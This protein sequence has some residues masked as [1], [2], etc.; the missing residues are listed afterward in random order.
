MTAEQHQF[1]A[2]VAKVLDIVINSLY[3]SKEIFL[4]ELISNA[5]DACDKL[6]Y[7]AL[8]N[9]DLLD[10]D[11]AYRISLTPDGEAKTLTI[12]DN[13]IGMNKDDLIT[14]LGTIA[15]SGTEAFVKAL[16]SG[17]DTVNQI[18]QF[19]VGFYSVFMV[20]SRAEVI[21]RKAGDAQAWKWASD[22][23]S[24]YSIEE[25]SKAT[26]GTDIILH[27]K[28]DQQ[29][30]TEETTLR[31]I[32]SRYSDH[33]DVPV[34]LQGKEGEPE[35]LNSGSALWTRNK[36][37]ITEDQYKEFYKHVSH[38]FDD[39]WHTMHYRA[40]G[41]IEYTG[42]L[43]V[44]T[45]KPLDLFDP[46]RKGH[47]KLYVRRVFITEDC[48]GLLPPYLRFL[49]GVVDTPDLPLN[50]SRELLQ[51]NP[52]LQKISNG[53]VK[54]V[55]S[56]LK[57][58]AK[59]ATAYATFWNAFGAVMKEGLYD[60]FARRE[61]LLEL[62]RFH[63]THGTELISLDD[64]IGRM[65]EGQ[66]DIYYLS[67]D[68]LETLRHSPQLEGFK[69]K[70]IEVLLLTDH[71]DEFW[72]PSVGQVQG[73][74]LKSAAAAGEDL[75]KLKSKTA[76]DKADETPEAELD[77]SA[78]IETLK[79]ELK[80]NVKDI[81]V[82]DRLTESPVCLVSAD[83]DMSMQLERLMRQHDQKVSIPT[84]IM[85]INPKH[86]LIKQLNGL[87]T[88][89]QDEALRDMAWVLLAQAKLVEGLELADPLD[90]A[91]RLTRVMEK[92]SA[93]S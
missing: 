60:D 29:Q 80:D 25:A 36:A 71:I 54:K 78:L 39:P 9:A 37:D 70:G 65:A 21:T 84:R 4:R 18:G 82:S 93:V 12:S 67:G 15:K 32:V 88:A 14:H 5:S 48:K 85:E 3:S 89:N 45:V 64:Y 27:L 50:I 81:R 8:T 46:N 41:A 75:S 61:Q 7:E 40:E 35:E 76:D 23:A 19:G 77:V 31:R 44:P 34:V 38:G 86:A 63:S 30:Y 53:L 22:G 52:L 56:E 43:Y 6:R 20:A 49:R 66:E 47:V 16:G 55:L 92:A 59:D 68:D 10:G 87:R 33:I 2:E 13:G 91:K 79:D 17:K 62:C 73:K 74:N 72:I 51:D 69:A 83:G 58:K 42:L 57:N 24:G 1:E 26:R 28:E 90:F 11:S